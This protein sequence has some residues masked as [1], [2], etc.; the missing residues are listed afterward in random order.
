[1]LNRKLL[2][3]SIAKMATVYSDSSFTGVYSTKDKLM[4]YIHD[5]GIL[6]IVEV[7]Y[8]SDVPNCMVFTGALKA[9]LD[10]DKG[11]NIDLIKSPDGQTIQ[12]GRADLAVR[13]SFDVTELLQSFHVDSSSSNLLPRKIGK[14]I[15][16]QFHT[17]VTTKPCTVFG[18]MLEI[19]NGV[20][21]FGSATQPLACW[22]EAEIDAPD[23]RLRIPDDTCAKIHKIIPH[24][25]S[26]FLG[27][28]VLRIDHDGVSH[29]IPITNDTP[30]LSLQDVVNLL[31]DEVFSLDDINLKDPVSTLLKF[32]EPDSTIV[33]RIAKGI[34][35]ADI[36][37]KVG[38]TSVDFAKFDKPLTM[39]FKVKPTQL[40]N[41][42]TSKPVGVSVVRR[43][44]HPHL[45]CF[46]E[47]GYAKDKDK[48]LETIDFRVKHIV[49]MAAVH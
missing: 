27:A 22:G 12:I 41:I 32:A 15:A 38:R 26:I 40:A 13:D 7:P 3:T 24:A 44:G 23:M 45:L 1:M 49:H 6:S 21:L 43:G 35:T 19:K 36:S 2:H 28:K 17:Y 39:D 37:S 14:L 16:T 33:F 20:A 5:R 8:K 34:M 31:Q 18:W 48:P 29:Y 10:Q 4:F 11:E 25:E 47:S 42:E 46:T 9:A 30:H